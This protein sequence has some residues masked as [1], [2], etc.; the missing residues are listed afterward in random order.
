MMRAPI[1]GKGGGRRRRV[2]RVA[3]VGAAIPL[4][5][6]GVSLGTSANAHTTPIL[7]LGDKNHCVAYVEEKV[8]GVKV[9]GIFDAHTRRAVMN[10]E[11]RHGLLANGIVGPSIWRR[12]GACP[13]G[14]NGGGNGA[15]TSSLAG[16]SCA[17]RL[18]RT[19]ADV[20][21]VACEVG[22]KF[23]VKTVYGFA[24]TGSKKCYSHQNGRAL[25]F[26][27]YKDKAKGDALVRYAQANAARL[28]IRY[29]VWYQRS[30]NPRRGTWVR[31]RDRGNVTLNHK[32]HPH[33]SFKC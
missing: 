22:R 23:N 9:D 17:Y 29:I 19:D 6:V 2:S 14:R 15:T 1:R 4:L 28:R 3:V 12:I 13:S 18:P 21:A 27:V 30:W 11:R 20:K 26:M 25:D 7:R 5:F 10:F 24:N 31:M 32:D 8:G 16:R 33:I